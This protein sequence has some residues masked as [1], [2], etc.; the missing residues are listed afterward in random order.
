MKMD[1]MIFDQLLLMT[2]SAKVSQAS[3]SKS[4]QGKDSANQF[5]KLMEQQQQQQTKPKTT[6]QSNNTAQTDSANNP[7]SVPVESGTSEAAEKIDAPV[8]ADDTTLENQ[9]ALAAMA[10]LQNPVNP[11]VD[12]TQDVALPGET[13][14]TGPE[15]IPVIAEDAP[16]E[17]SADSVQNS[18]AEMQSQ[19]G[20]VNSEKADDSILQQTDLTQSAQSTQ[21]AEKP[22][23]FQESIQ[24]VQHTDVNSEDQMAAGVSEE[25]EMPTEVDA[26]L[27][28]PVFH[29]VRDIPV[30]V[31]DVPETEKP[32]ETVDIQTQ[33][34]EKLTEAVQN[35]DTK[36]SLQLEPESLGK[37]TIEMTWSRDGALHV[38]MHADNARTQDLLSRN[39]EN[40]QS[41]LSRDTRQ[42]VQVEVPRQEE[43][44]RQQFYDGRQGNG[45]QQE[46]RQQ[47]RHSSR[48][49]QNDNENFL[50]QLRLGLIPADPE[51]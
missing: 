33:I 35:G 40:L 7:D 37:V 23:D 27:E 10:V 14:G 18:G 19:E 16:L 46:S 4:T 5:R 45:Q 20:F 13:G 6:A 12:P 29:E 50:H 15:L 41:L 26:N 34:G 22:R 44:Q 17:L 9:M 25:S 2:Q 24:R 39:T 51:D 31:G 47:G 30:K 38:A 48:E 11:I 21:A 36:L 43:S 42:E 32:Y 8:F 3:L 1:Q 28:T 49:N